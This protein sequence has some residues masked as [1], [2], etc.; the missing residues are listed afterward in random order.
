MVIF[1]CPVCGY[2]RLIKAPWTLE[3]GGSGEICP[4]CGIQF[5]YTDSAGG[6]VIARHELYKD[7]RREW[8]ANGMPWDKGRSVPPPGWNPVEQL[9][10]IGVDLGAPN[11]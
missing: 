3:D 10:N 11:K 5:G 2:N 1:T 8:I 7:W 4:C 9:K 6:S